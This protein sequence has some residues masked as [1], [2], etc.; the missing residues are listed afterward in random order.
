M[1]NIVFYIL[2]V[3]LMKLTRVIAKCKPELPIVTARSTTI[4]YLFVRKS[5]SLW[6]TFPPMTL[7]FLDSFIL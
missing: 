3:V 2:M 4:E 7:L 1:G 6:I 5:L